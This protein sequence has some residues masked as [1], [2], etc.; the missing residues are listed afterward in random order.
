MGGVDTSTVSFPRDRDFEG[1]DRDRCAGGIGG[2][3]IGVEPG[4]IVFDL[5]GSG[6]ASGAV[7]GLGLTEKDVVSTHEQ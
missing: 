1:D 7:C 4:V 6:L 2:R 5:D 3:I